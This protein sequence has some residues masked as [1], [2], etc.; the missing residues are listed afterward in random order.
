MSTW[1]YRIVK[2]RGEGPLGPWEA[3]ELCEVFYDDAGNP[4]SRTG[5]VGF[6]CD[7][8]EGPEGVTGSL[9]MALRDAR[10]KPVLDENDIGSRGSA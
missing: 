3:Y 1:N 5:A 2:T 4:E 9:E 8:D 7:A 10:D 6:A